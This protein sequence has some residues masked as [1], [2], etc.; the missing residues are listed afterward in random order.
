MQYP[1]K[2]RGDVLNEAFAAELYDLIE[3]SGPDF[4]IF[5][6]HHFNGSDFEI[7]KTYLCTNQLGYVKF[8]E[9]QF[10]NP[11]KTISV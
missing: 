8:G 10:F 3:D 4:W 9:H 11:S 2:Y 7:R 5:G 6:H 1:E